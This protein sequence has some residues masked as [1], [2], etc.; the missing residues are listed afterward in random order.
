MTIETTKYV[1][2]SSNSFTL[3]LRVSLFKICTI[4]FFPNHQPAIIPNIYAKE[5]HL[6]ARNPKSIKTGSKLWVYII[7]YIIIEIKIIIK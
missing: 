7:S 6:I 2:K 5:Y 3:N 1:I 4:I